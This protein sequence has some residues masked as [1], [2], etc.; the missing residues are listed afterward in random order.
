MADT[1]NVDLTFLARQ[2][3]AILEELR[4]VRHQL[5]D[6]RSLL[7]GLTEQGRRFDRRLN[8][9]VPEMELMI[10]GEIMGR[11]AR[12]DGQVDDKMEDLTTPAW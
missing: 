10:K 7:L 12:Y 1:T 9:L 4:D 8:D 5:A 11:F 3:S 2:N 6:H